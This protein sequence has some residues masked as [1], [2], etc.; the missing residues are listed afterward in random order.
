VF[1]IPIPLHDFWSGLHRV[2]K[3]GLKRPDMIF[4]ISVSTVVDN[5]PKIKTAIKEL[6]YWLRNENKQLIY[7]YI[8]VYLRIRANDRTRHS[9]N[10]I[11]KR[12]RIEL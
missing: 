12:V 7:F 6:K 1:Y 5:A 4:K 11:V 3:Y 8:Q 2:K 10:L 9:L